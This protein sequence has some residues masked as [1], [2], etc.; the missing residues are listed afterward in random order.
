MKIITWNCNMAFRKKV[1]QLLAYLP[2]LLIIPECEHPKK[3]L[4]DPTLPQPTTALWFGSNLNKGLGIFSFGEFR[5]KLRRIHNPDFRMVVP[6]TVKSPDKEFS[7]YAIWA[8]NPD[9]LDGQYVEQVWKA[10]HYYKKHLKNKNTI[11][12]GDFNS[13]TI[14]DRKRRE[15]NHSNVVRF[16]N[17]KNIHSSYH[18]FHKQEQGKERDATLYMYRH[19]DKPYHIDY[20]FVSGD[21]IERIKSVE[22][23]DFDYW[24]RFSDH[25]PLMVDFHSHISK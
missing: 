15:G 1:A 13:N 18:S 17:K 23:G 10:L 22:I 14:W 7:L 20:C 6:I 16:L 19:K 5:L 8:N 12:A 21:M 25:V 4:F 2:D 9:D 3:I 24:T 11:L